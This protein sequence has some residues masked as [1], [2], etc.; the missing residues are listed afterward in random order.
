MKK[1][2]VISVL[3]VLCSTFAL[4][5]SFIS[6]TGDIEFDTSLN[7]IN[8]EAKADLTTF[9]TDISVSFNVPQAEVTRMVTVEKIEPAD[10]YM[11]FEVAKIE[12]KPVSEV[13]TVYK[14]NKGKGWGV[15]AKELGIKPGSDAFKQ[16]KEKSKGKSAKKNK[17]PEGGKGNKK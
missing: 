1:F 5:G 14:K 16:L 2:M 11:I 3:M 4:A 15:T 17:K 7:D 8:I 13:T 6:L 9:S 12:N 10:V